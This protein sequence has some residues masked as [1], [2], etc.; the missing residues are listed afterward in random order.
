MP[1]ALVKAE[2]WGWAWQRNLDGTIS[3]LEAGT[4]GEIDTD[5]YTAQV[6]GTII[7]PGDFATDDDGY[8]PGWVEYGEYQFSVD[9]GSAF[10]VLAGG[11]SGSPESPDLEDVRAYAFNTG[12]SDYDEGAG[13]WQDSQGMIHNRGVLYYAGGGNPAIPLVYPVPFQP[14]IINVWGTVVGQNQSSGAVLTWVFLINA[15][16]QFVLQSLPASPGPALPPSDW[17][18]YMNSIAPYRIDQ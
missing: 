16:G 4:L 8:F 14:E 9:G 15:G 5:V 18:L 1:R 2:A 13:Y 12:W 3:A 6:G 17:A 10:T 11:G 7:D